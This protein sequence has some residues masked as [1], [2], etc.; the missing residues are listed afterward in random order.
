[1][2]LVVPAFVLYLLSEVFPRPE[3]VAPIV[4]AVVVF[5][6]TYLLTAIGFLRERAAGTL[7]RKIRALYLARL[8][9]HLFELAEI[10]VDKMVLYLSSENN[11]TAIIRCK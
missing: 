4:L 1:M 6:M 2:V 10:S 3:P 7:S 5:F 11:F 9:E 8:S